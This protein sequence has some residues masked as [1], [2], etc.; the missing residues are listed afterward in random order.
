M[1]YARRLLLSAA[2]VAAVFAP[3]AQAAPPPYRPAALTYEVGTTHILVHYTADPADK[4][5]DRA[6]GCLA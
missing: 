2:F 1:G 6:L 5:G 3:A 4:A